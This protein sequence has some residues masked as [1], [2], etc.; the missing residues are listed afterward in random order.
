MTATTNDPATTE[1]ADPPHFKLTAVEKART[2]ASVCNSGTLCTIATQSSAHPSVPG[3][4]FGSHVDYV[5]DDAGRPV[6]L[7]NEMSLHTTF[8]NSPGSRASLFCQMVKEGS[9]SQ[10]NPRVTITGSVELLPQ[11]DPD[12]DALKTR[13]SISHS[14]ADRVMDS[15]LFK[16]YR[17]VPEAVYYVG[18]FGVMSTWVDV[19]EYAVS[20]AD[21]LAPHAGSIIERLNRE[22]SQDVRG[23]ADY[24]L[25]VG[26]EIDSAVLTNVD[27][28]GI[29]VRVTY[30][31]GRGRRL[32]TDEYRVGYSLPVHTLEDAKSEIIK[33]FQVAWERGQGIEWDD[34][35][36]AEPPVYKFAADSL[37]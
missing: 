17:L 23:V 37:G 3:S 24:L 22:S 32:T 4:P 15:K 21:V 33:L 35:E 8:V 29:D 10:N 1:T 34:D 6:L 13:Y 30:K 16:F 20:E 2:V 28:L 36:D 27:R 7:M 9:N 14:Y 12:F 25:D 19:E 26:G 5:L 18:G 31:P 11:D